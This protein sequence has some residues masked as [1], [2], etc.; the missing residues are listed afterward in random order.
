MFLRNVGDLLS[1]FTAS[2]RRYQLSSGDM[3]DLM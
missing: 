2:H 1:D 3:F